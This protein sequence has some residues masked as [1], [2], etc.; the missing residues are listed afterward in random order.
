MN[1][2]DLSIIVTVFIA[3]VAGAVFIGQLDGRMKNIENKGL[4]E[5]Y[6][7]LSQELEKEANKK[8]TDIKKLSESS[9]LVVR[10]KS[11]SLELNGA[12][13]DVLQKETLWPEADACFLTKISGR[14]GGDGELV[15]IVE[16]RDIWYLQ[17]HSM[18]RD[19]RAVK[20]RALCIQYKLD[21]K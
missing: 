11:Y 1:R 2:I 4:D 17:G 6:D 20:A 3:I 19:S 16:S 12:G 14:F 8:I 10:T 7:E 18:Q 15:E 21:R 13:R 9:N 5:K